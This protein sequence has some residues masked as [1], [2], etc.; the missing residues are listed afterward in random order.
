MTRKFWTKEEEEV[1]KKIHT[2]YSSKELAEMFDT[3]I[4]AINTKKASLGIAK[5]QIEEV[6]PEGYRKC[7][8][9]KE[10][11][12]EEE[13][14]HRKKGDPTSGYSHHCKSCDSLRK[15]KANRLKKI[16]KK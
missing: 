11:L 6:L 8:A 5:H 3:S 14:Y 1:L 13:F 4:G 7:S 12:P 10:V 15:A 9:C 16:D 2:L